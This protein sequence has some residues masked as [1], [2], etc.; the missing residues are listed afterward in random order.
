MN[1]RVVAISLL[2]AGCAEIKMPQPISLPSICMGEQTCEARKNAETLAIMGYHDAALTIMCDDSRV[3][4]VLE[5]ECGSS[6][7]SYP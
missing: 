1:G 5:V 3:R 4:G 2:L 7:L 6:S